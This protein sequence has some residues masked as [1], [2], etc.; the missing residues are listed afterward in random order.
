[1][2]NSVA[3]AR[4]RHKEQQKG[5]SSTQVPPAPIAASYIPRKPTLNQKIQLLTDSHEPTVGCTT[6]FV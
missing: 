1:M 3:K 5:A 6:L 4:L 2:H